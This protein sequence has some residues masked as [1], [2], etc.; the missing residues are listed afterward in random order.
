MPHFKEQT[1]EVQTM[2]FGFRTEE[3]KGVTGHLNLNAVLVVRA[4]GLGR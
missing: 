4:F 2:S 3:S 1:Q